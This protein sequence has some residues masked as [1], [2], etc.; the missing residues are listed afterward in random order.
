MYAVPGR[1]T[2]TFRHLLRDVVEIADVME[3]LH[4]I[5]HRC[6]EVRVCM[7]ESARRDARHKIK[8]FLCKNQ[9]KTADRAERRRWAERIV[10]RFYSLKQGDCQ[11]ACLS[12]SLQALDS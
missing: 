2:L 5:S 10:R 6:R 11:R 8:V 12:K 9:E 4:L 1:Q 3:L 7:P